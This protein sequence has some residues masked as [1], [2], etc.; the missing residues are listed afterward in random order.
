MNRLGFSVLINHKE[1]GP[2][3]GTAGAQNRGT[4]WTLEDTRGDDASGD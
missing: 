4:R 1:N 2:R 3:R